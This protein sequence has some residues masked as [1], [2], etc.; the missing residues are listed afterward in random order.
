MDTRTRSRTIF[1][2]LKGIIVKDNKVPMLDGT[3]VAIDRIAS[4]LSSGIDEEEVRYLLKLSL[5]QM[6][7]YN[8]FMYLCFLRVWKDNNISVIPYSISVDS[9]CR[10]FLLDCEERFDSCEESLEAD[11]Y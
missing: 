3:N 10:R 9:S 5:E 2:K 8:K 6:S 4:L 1:P 11:V 7:T